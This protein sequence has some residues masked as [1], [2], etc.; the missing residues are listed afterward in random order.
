[1]GAGVVQLKTGTSISAGNGIAQNWGSHH[2]AWYRQ[3]ISTESS[4]GPAHKNDNQL[5]NPLRSHAIKPTEFYLNLEE[6]E[7]TNDVIGLLHEK[8]FYF[9]PFNQAI[10][11]GVKPLLAA[12]QMLT[13]VMKADKI[14]VVRASSNNDFLGCVRFTE[15]TCKQAELS[16]FFNPRH[17]KKYLGTQSVLRA[18]HWF[19]HEQ[20]KPSKRLIATVDPENVASYRILRGSGFKINERGMLTPDDV[21]NPYVDN[22]GNAR[23]RL[24]ME[25]RIPKDIV[26]VLSVAKELSRYS[27]DT[28]VRA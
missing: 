8:G 16:Y 3:N 28:L 7:A 2:N 1:M 14:F 4:A 20:E 25:G 23:S 17:Y 6:L 21:S 22:K 11:D 24:V 18:I 13:G 9:A 27:L 19:I 12:A 26:P 10:K 15:M 5:L